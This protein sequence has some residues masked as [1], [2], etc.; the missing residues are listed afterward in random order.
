MNTFEDYGQLRKYWTRHD[1]MAD[2]IWSIQKWS[3]KSENPK[4]QEIL[5]DMGLL[6]AVLANIVVSKQDKIAQL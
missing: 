4:A 3:E 1:P 6:W 5:C 2:L